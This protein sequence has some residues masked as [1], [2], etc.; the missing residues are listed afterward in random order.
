[1]PSGQ[2]YAQRLREDAQRTLAPQAN[3]LEQELNNIKNDLLLSLGQL[4][5][6]LEALRSLALPE[7]ES[8]VVEAFQE[9]TRV[10]DLR[11]GSIAR[12]AHE[13]R[14]K[15]TQE[16]ILQLLLDEAGKLAPRV[17]LFI[18]RGGKLAGWSSRGFPTEVA[19]QIGDCTVEQAASPLFQRAIESETL[20]TSAAVDEE[21]ALDF[22][23]KDAPAPWHA[24]PMLAIGRPVAL[25]LAASANGEKCDLESLCILLD[26]TGM[27]IENLALKIMNESQVQQ[28]PSTP[29][30]V[31][32]QETPS[33]EGS[34][35]VVV[36]S[37]AEPVEESSIPEEPMPPTFQE[38]PS[39]SATDKDAREESTIESMSDSEPQEELPAPEVEEPAA[40]EREE[41][42]SVSSEDQ[43]AGGFPAGDW[44]SDTAVRPEAAATA[45]TG[46]PLASLQPSEEPQAQPTSGA[47]VQPAEE[48]KLLGDARRFARLLV[49][50]IKLYNEQRV[51]DGRQNKDIYVRL[52]KDIDK[53]REMY[54]KRVPSSITRK[55][56][57]FH[58]EVIRILGDNDPSTLG[59]DYPGPRVES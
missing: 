35:E 25:L 44:V 12:F 55:I 40:A 54:D 34:P 37:A 56:D 31:G 23:R 14:R 7:A 58:D 43:S 3:D 20:A 47:A 49:S 27:C 15:E 16:E 10:K 45:D 41:Q 36:E 51:L 59:S 24:F 9:A 18:A 33:P 32:S 48:D 46:A 50:E 1:M 38:E 11:L 52:K 4:G 22:V 29:L 30:V 53:S 19:A 13:I 2:E 26:L 17:A 21:N 42:S 39:G 57:Y 28:A 8:I 5:Q 6:K